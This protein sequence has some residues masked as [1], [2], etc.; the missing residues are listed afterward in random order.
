MKKHYILLL[1]IAVF[2]ITGCQNFEKDTVTQV[3]TINALLAGFYDGQIT[4]RNLKSY[5]DCGLGT[6]DGLDGEMVLL[7]GT[8]YQIKSDG[9][10][11]FPR[12]DQTVP[13]ATVVNFQKDLTI[14][15]SD[16]TDLSEL[17]EEVNKKI[18]NPNIFCAIRLKGKFSKMKTRSVF[19]QHKPYPPMTEVTKN[20]PVFEMSDISGTIVGFR[21]PA[22]MK[23]INFNGLHLHF[24]SED[25]KSGGHILSFEMEQGTAGLDIANRFLMLL[26]NDQG[27][28][29]KLDLSRDRT[30]ELNKAEK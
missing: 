30:A 4:L 1:G 12:S 20:Q 2:C 15:L 9:R 10:V 28:F 13:F 3:S 24:L 16:K 27:D 14:Q 21:M 22:Y 5:G 6:F 23:G 8:V 29:S 17:E 7:D 25:R 26:P 18:A 11:Y 19:A